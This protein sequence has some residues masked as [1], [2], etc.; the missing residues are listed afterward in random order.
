M[1]RGGDGEVPHVERHGEFDCVVARTDG[2]RGLVVARRGILGQRLG[3]CEPEVRSPLTEATDETKAAIEE[4]VRRV[5]ELE[6]ARRAAEEKAQAAL[7]EK[8]LYP[9][10]QKVLGDEIAARGLVGITVE[11][12]WRRTFPEGIL[13]AHALGFV[14]AE[15]QGYYGVEGYYDAELRG[16]PGTRVYQR[17]PWDQLIPLGL[18]DDERWSTFEAKCESVAT[19]QQ[20]FAGTS[21]MGARAATLLK[22]QLAQARE[23]LAASGQQA[24]TLQQRIAFNVSALDLDAPRLPQVASEQG[25]LGVQDLAEP[26]RGRSI[27]QTRAAHAE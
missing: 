14:N 11:P 27:H 7:Q 6:H 1:P 16:Q 12:V 19:E 18:V 23:Q 20:R 25:E 3:L 5:T 9:D 10:V 4:A 26:P 17:D 8:N 21:A 22:Q 24:G 2:Q 15:G 13:A